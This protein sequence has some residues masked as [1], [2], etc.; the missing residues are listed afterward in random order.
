M[1]PLMTGRWLVAARLETKPNTG[2]KERTGAFS[3]QPLSDGPVPL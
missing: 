1:L 2:A 3:A